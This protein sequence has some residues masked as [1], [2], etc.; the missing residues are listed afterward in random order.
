MHISYGKDVY[1]GILV[2]GLKAAELDFILGLMA[3]G[4]VVPF[5]CAYMVGGLEGVWILAQIVVRC[6]DLTCGNRSA[7]SEMDEV[8]AEKFEAAEI[9]K[10]KFLQYSRLVALIILF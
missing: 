10:G 4:T 8:E 2:T 7:E 1:E 3:F 9:M 5:S 6:W